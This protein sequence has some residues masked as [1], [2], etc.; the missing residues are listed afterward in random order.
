MLKSALKNYCQRTYSSAI[1]GEAYVCAL[2]YQLGMADHD[3]YM[4]QAV[5]AKY[6]QKVVFPENLGIIPVAV[7][8][9]GVT[10]RLCMARFGTMVMRLTKSLAVM[11]GKQSEFRPLP[12]I[13]SLVPHQRD[14]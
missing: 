6:L 11:A 1:A 10:Y 5:M 7:F 14:A 8:T 9:V 3:T 4:K 2:G 12:V 13:G